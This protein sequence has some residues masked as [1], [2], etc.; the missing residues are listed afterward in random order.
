[1]SCRIICHRHQSSS[2]LGSHSNVNLQLILHYHQRLL[3]A[4]CFQTLPPSLVA[5]TGRRYIHAAKAIPNPV[6]AAAG[7][8]KRPR[9]PREGTVEPCRRCRR[10]S[11]EQSSQP[12]FLSSVAMNGY[13]P[14]A[15]HP[16]D[17]KRLFSRWL[18]SSRTRHPAAQEKFRFLG[19]RVM[20]GLGCPFFRR[21]RFPRNHQT[22]NGMHFSVSKPN[23]EPPDRRRQSC[24][25]SARFGSRSELMIGNPPTLQLSAAGLII[26]D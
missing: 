4:G 2:R 19:G 15:S 7:Q 5:A 20:H 16:F 26:F 12:G 1:L 10:C 8:P 6:R 24:P 22:G 18:D 13:N 25:S 3:H 14:T 23:A 11:H 21:F 9:D 17:I